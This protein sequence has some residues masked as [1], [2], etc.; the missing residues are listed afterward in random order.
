MR[1]KTSKYRGVHEKR[2]WGV[3]K[4][5]AQVTVKG[6]VHYIG[7]YKTE[8]EAA[9]SFDLFVIRMNINRKTNFLKKKQ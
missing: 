6:V 2:Q 1:K 8:I 9:K 4:Y 3:K 5:T 7:T